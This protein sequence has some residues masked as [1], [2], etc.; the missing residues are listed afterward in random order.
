M[1]PLTPTLQ[2]SDLNFSALSKN[3]SILSEGQ[4][5]FPLFQ[6]WKLLIYLVGGEHYSVTA[7]VRRHLTGLSFFYHVG[8]GDQT[9]PG[10]QAWWLSTLLAEPSLA[11]PCPTV[12][13]TLTQKQRLQFKWPARSS[14]L[15]S[16]TTTYQLFMTKVSILLFSLWLWVF[17]TLLS[18]RLLKVTR[19][20]CT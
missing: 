2:T 1:V 11:N 14:V 17:S 19:F 12:Y 15:S 6:S 8:P 3:K 20:L 18:P 13:L 16:P 4:V 9:D 10:H 5:L 7:E